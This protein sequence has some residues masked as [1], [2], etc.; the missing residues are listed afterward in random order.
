MSKL[1]GGRFDGTTHSLME[2]LGE[3]VSFDHRLAPWDIEASRAHAKMLAA[4]GIITKEEGSLLD[5]GL[6]ELAEEVRNGSVQWDSRLEDVH[7]NIEALLIKKSEMPG[8]NCILPG[9]ETIRLLPTCVFGQEIRL[10]PL[11]PPFMRCS[12]P[13]S[14]LPKSTFRLCSRATPIYSPHSQSCWHIICLPI[15]KCFQ[16]TGNVLPN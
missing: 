1:W 12:M 8:K 7:G 3:S 9:V 4:C 10:M 14:I 11:M 5:Q 2:K 6:A 13:F 15:L 16:E